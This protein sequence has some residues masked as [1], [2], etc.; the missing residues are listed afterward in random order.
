MLD[1]PLDAS[2]RRQAQ[3]RQLVQ[4]ELA[5]GVGDR[6]IPVH[7]LERVT[8]AAPT[9][10]VAMTAA[11]S[12][13]LTAPRARGGGPRRTRPVPGSVVSRPGVDEV[14]VLGLAQRGDQ[15]VL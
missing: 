3:V 6:G 5:G 2:A 13:R 12:S 11:T 8:D 9:S 15:L 7:Q 10:S 1:D 4:L 14:Q